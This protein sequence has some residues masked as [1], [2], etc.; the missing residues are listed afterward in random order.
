M[1][2]LHGQKASKARWEGQ[3]DLNSELQKAMSA[4]A[5]PRRR[6]DNDPLGE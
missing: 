3:L 2:S 1:G 5:A 6:Y 4:P